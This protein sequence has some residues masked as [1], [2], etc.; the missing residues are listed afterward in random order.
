[1]K[2]IL[3]KILN[4]IVRSIKLD[5]TDYRIAEDYQTVKKEV[6]PLKSKITFRPSMGDNRDI[7]AI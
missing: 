3:E 2:K 7:S 6:R 1:M 4:K 5:S